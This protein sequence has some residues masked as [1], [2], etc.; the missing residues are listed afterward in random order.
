ME[1]KL[2][3]FETA[4]I[5]KARGFNV[6]CE[7][8]FSEHF[9]GDIQENN[10]SG[11]RNW[12]KEYENSFSRPTQSLLQKW[13]REIHNLDVEPEK[14]QHNED[15]RY[16]KC[17]VWGEEF[18]NVGYVTGFDSYEEALEEGLLCALAAIEIK[19]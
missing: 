12:N 19:N 10:Q 7:N 15:G 8:Y 11:F 17:R 5:A 4:K 14:Y 16:Y 13:F 9:T 6:V 18:E 3:E 2:I 1:E